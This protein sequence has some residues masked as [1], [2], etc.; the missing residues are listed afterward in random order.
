MEVDVI[1]C[2]VGILRLCIIAYYWSRFVIGLRL[3][4]LG[5]S[6]FGEYAVG[7]VIEPNYIG[8]GG[9]VGE[10]GEEPE[11]NDIFDVHVFFY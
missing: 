11:S 5:L 8:V 9:A 1:F 2:F 10:V 7:L 4:L 6:W 3:R